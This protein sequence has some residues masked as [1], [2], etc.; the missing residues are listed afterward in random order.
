MCVCV[1]HIFFIHSSVDEHLSC[2]HILA[3]VNS[4]TVN[5]EIH[6]LFQI[7]GFFF[8]LARYPEME[9]LDCMVV[10]FLVFWGTSKHF[11][12]WLYQFT[13]HQ[14]CTRAPFSLY[15]H[16]HLSFVIFLKIDKELNFLMSLP[17]LKFYEIL[18]TMLIYFWNRGSLA[19]SLGPAS[20]ESSSEFTYR[21]A[22][23][24]KMVQEDP[25]VFCSL[26]FS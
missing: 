10:L 1:R 6:R 22:S 13:S 20:Q 14:Q 11:C 24:L 4:P 5:I 7:C 25:I 8:P 2:C 23:A 18:W 12:S 3:V 26:Q 9:L 19:S 17:F 16:Q 21:S 15:L